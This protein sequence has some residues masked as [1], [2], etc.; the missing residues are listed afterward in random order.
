V[1]C[2]YSIVHK[3]PIH[4]P[5]THLRSVRELDSLRRDTAV[6]R[7][8]T[9]TVAHQSMVCEMNVQKV[10]GWRVVCGVMWCGL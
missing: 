1:Y 5:H 10:G 2:L 8:D 7:R 3:I 9:K 4:T 6:L